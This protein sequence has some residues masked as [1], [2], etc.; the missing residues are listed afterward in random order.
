MSADELREIVRVA[1]RDRV[2]VDAPGAG[3]ELADGYA[4]QRELFD[5][6]PLAGYKLGVVSAAK[7]AQMGLPHPVYGHVA[8]DMLL[9]SPVSIRRFIQP[10][11]E[12][13]LAVVLR[14]ALPAGATPGA[15]AR[16]VG[17]A[18]L[19]VDILDSVWADYRFGLAEVVADNTSGGGFLLGE[20][21]L[22]LDGAGDLRLHLDGELVAQGPVS[23]IG[24]WQAN[25][26]WLAED[27]GGVDAGTVVFLGSPAAA[28]PLRPGLLELYG[29][30][31]GVLLAQITEGEDDR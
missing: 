6:R 11:C 31:D 30:H 4:I 28:V 10:R 9:G 19:A 7:Q 20:R 22:P 21:S 15:A 14:H 8:E 25:L 24:D 5:G 12:P 13:E 17:A 29:P 23:A 1:R 18:V 27:T 26:A 3:V 2:T 16:A